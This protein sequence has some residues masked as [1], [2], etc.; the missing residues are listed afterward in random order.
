VHARA[1]DVGEQLAAWVHHYN[2]DRP[3]ESLG[4]LC[5]IDRVCE[6]AAKTPLWSEV[7]EAYE[8]KDERLQVSEYV[9]EKSL[10]KLKRFLWTAHRMVSS[11]CGALIQTAVMFSRL[12][13]AS[14][15]VAP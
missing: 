2:W 1:P 9:V 11:N 5:P 3:H 10:R 6:R 4:G 8:A 15:V 12:L 13:L 14:P 7:S